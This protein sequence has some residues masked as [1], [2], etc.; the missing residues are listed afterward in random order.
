MFVDSFSFEVW[1][2][3]HLTS[4]YLLSFSTQSFES[5]SPSLRSS[6]LNALKKR[7][8][9][10]GNTDHDKPS[11]N[12]SL[13]QP[14]SRCTP[15]APTRPTPVSERPPPLKSP[16]LLTAQEGQRTASCAQQPS[17][18]APAGEEQR[19]MDRDE[20]THN[21][22]PEKLEEQVPT[23]PRASYE[24]PRVPLNNLKMRFEKGEDN[25][26]KVK[27]VALSNPFIAEHV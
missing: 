2:E 15:L 8:E 6:N 1:H 10:A 18:A 12:A 11:S 19:G 9:Q 20:L 21:E 25:T 5:A 3:H 14:S 22:R 16:G 27:S 24:K 13:I 4:F 7:W 17:A 26:G 23:S